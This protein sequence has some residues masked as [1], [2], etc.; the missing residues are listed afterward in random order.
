MNENMNE[1][2]NVEVVDFENDYESTEET[3]SGLSPKAIAA[4]AGGVVAVGGIAAAILLANKEKID[5]WRVRRM[6]QKLNKRGFGVVK[7]EDGQ[8]D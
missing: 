2:M 4:I 1:N 5:A 8:D 3:S 6:E 7:L